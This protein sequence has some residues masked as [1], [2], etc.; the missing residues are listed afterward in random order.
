MCFH[1]KQTKNGLELEKQYKIPL[2]QG[3]HIEPVTYVNGF[4]HPQVPIVAHD[5]KKIELA[6][7]G[8]MPSFATDKSFAKNTLNARIETL[9]D[10]P[11][12]MDYTQNRCLI[13]ADG[14]YEWQWLNSKGTHKQAYFITSQHRLFAMGGI[15]AFYEDNYEQKTIKTVSILTTQANDLMCEIHNTKKRMPVVIKPQDFDVW[16]GGEDV[17]KF[18][19]P[20]QVEL[21]AQKVMKANNNYRLF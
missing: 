19:Y 21:K 9:Q 8:L 10:K 14:F 2:S 20:Y 13:L 12:F 18:G 11:S 17:K 5:Q 6:Q 7:W 1:Y 4:A 16:L 3:V 15:Y